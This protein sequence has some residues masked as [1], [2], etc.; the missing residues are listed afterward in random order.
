MCWGCEE[1]FGFGLSVRVFAFKMNLMRLR[2][3]QLLPLLLVLCLP[4]SGQQ[5]FKKGDKLLKLKAFDLA[6]DSYENGLKKNPDHAMGY[7]Q[8][9]E[10]YRLTNRLLES[11]K[12]YEKAFSIDSDLKKD[13]QLQYAHTLKKVGMYEKAFSNYEELAAGGMEEVAY[14]SQSVDFAKSILSE[15]DKYDILSFDGNSPSSDFGIGFFKDNLIFSSF[16]DD[17]PR[18]IDKKNASYISITGNQLYTVNA[19]NIID[20]S[21]ISHLRPDFK[22]IYALGPLSYSKDGSMVAYMKNGF[23]DGVIQPLPDEGNYSIYFA[24]SDAGGDFSSSKPFP[25][26]QVEYS[27]AYPSLSFNG[28]ALY[29][30]S[31]KPGGYGGFDLYVSYFKDG[32][33]TVPENLGEN[34]N[35]SGNEITPYFED[36]QLYYSSDYLMGLGGYDIFSSRVEGGR[37]AAAENLGKGINS[38]SDDYYFVPSPNEEGYYFTSNRL[39]GRGKDDIY[40]AYPLGENEEILALQDAAN[41]PPAMSM[42]VQPAS[43][44]PAE[45]MAVE[46]STSPQAR[47]VSTGETVNVAKKVSEFAYEDEG[48]FDYIGAT[49][50]NAPK[51]EKPMMM[52]NVYF[53]QLASFTQSKGDASAF[54]GLTRHGTL[55]RF[56]KNNTVKVRLG[57]FEDKTT[58]LQVLQEV[59]SSGFRDAFITTDAL[60]VANFEVIEA[61]S[62]NNAQSANWISEYTNSSHYKV[63][64]ASYK[65]PLKFNVDAVTDL[66]RLEQWSKG[67]WTIFILGGYASLEEAQRAQI[68]AMNRGFVDAELVR[69]DDGLLSK[70]QNR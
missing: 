16:R 25:Y 58:A 56:F 64:L 28:S 70:V 38:P 22:E 19:A 39:G 42:P 69:D 66:G 60:S 9:A 68:R 45:D 47:L 59:K 20:K 52:N 5:E 65:D 26:N 36:E 53:I 2:I 11:I 55:Y 8:L 40:I 10:A 30:S 29:F 62:N 33:W 54:T 6:I 37:W 27:Y 63:K 43:D 3:Y 57:Y 49:L 34:I 17:M 50:K 51:I 7:G 46:S 24:L 18:E 21:A 67:Q 4:L 61:G 14:Y 23:I 44:L 32:Q 1:S 35:T 31:N 48:E 13:F 41:I 15:K 12:A